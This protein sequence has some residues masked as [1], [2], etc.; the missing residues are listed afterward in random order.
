MIISLVLLCIYQSFNTPVMALVLTNYGIPDTQI[1]YIFA[2]PCI[3]YIFSTVVIALFIKKLPRRLLFF[4]S[5]IAITIA[6]FLM[7][8]SILLGLP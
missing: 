2:I 8:P 4:S 6:L 3:T 5:F 7:G 1:G